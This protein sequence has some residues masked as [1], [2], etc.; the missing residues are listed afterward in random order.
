MGYSNVARNMGFK[1]H[2]EAGKKHPFTVPRPVPAVRN[3]SDG[4]NAS[5]DLAIG[6]AYGI[7]ANGNAFRAGPNDP[8]RGIVMAIRFVASSLVMNGNGPVS[9]DYLANGATGVIIGAED[10]QA[11]WEVQ[12]NT[13][14]ITNVGQMVNLVD[15]APDAT[16]SQSRQ[17]VD[18]NSTGNQFVVEGFIDSLADNALGTNA[19]VYVKLAQTFQE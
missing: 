12:A 9:N 5:F 10:A 8:V 1:L 7:D 17:S 4:G 14:Q 15:A 18:L 19:R 6:D 2:A 11:L 13:F 3:V 16:L